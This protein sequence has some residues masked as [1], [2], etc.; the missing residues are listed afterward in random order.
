MKQ[1]TFIQLKNLYHMK[2]S[3]LNRSLCVVFIV[4]SSFLSCFADVV[5]LSA[6][7]NDSQGDGSFSKPYKSLD[8]AAQ[9]ASAG[10]TILAMGGIY[11]A[12]QDFTCNGAAG[13]PILVMPV[14]GET[15]VFDGTS[16]SISSTDHLVN[17]VRCSYV[18]FDGFEVRNSSGRGLS[19]TECT[20][21]C[22]RNCNI[23]DV[24]QRVLGGSGDSVT[25]EANEVWNGCLSNE[26]SAYGSG[27]WPGA[28]QTARWWSTG[29]YPSN[30]IIKGNYIHDCWG[31]GIIA[32]F[33]HGGEITGNTVQNVYSCCMYLDNAR[34][35]LVHKNHIIC[36]TDDYNRLDGRRPNGI[37]LCMESYSNLLNMPLENI[38]IYNNLITGTYRGINYWFDSQNT[39]TNNSYANIHFYHN[40]IKG[41][42]HY[43]IYTSDVPSGYT[44]PHGC[45]IKN[46]IIYAGSAGT[47]SLNDQAAWSLDNNCYPNGVPSIDKGANSFADDPGFINPVNGGPPEGFMITTASSC[48]KTGADLS[49][50]VPEDWWGNAR[51]TSPSIGIHEYQVV[52]ALEKYTKNNQNADFIVYPNPCSNQ[53]TIADKLEKAE[54]IRISIS[55]ILGKKYFKEKNISGDFIKQ[56]DISDMN[57]GI[58][59]ISIYTGNKL[60]IQK[61]IKQ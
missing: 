4:F 52:T 17:L 28:V 50:N 55:N 34:D 10:D 30:I 19:F 9:D 26:N 5:Y 59:F 57:D 53:L 3:M 16:L 14:S 20:N 35:I 2:K 48:W 22:I 47:L 12:T 58:Y 25:L 7:G 36:T 21:I 54:T 24:Q 39:L 11:N 31:E 23:H 60:T 18:I 6:N 41:I 45:F 43:S 46:N 27:G 15:A 42:Q 32:N 56:I 1:K 51:S 37:S 13:N 44:Q 40:I 61:L 29:V 38:L 8:R 49:A 33:L